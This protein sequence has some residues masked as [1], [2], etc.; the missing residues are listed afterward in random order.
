MNK[1][2]DYQSAWNRLVNREY[3]YEDISSVYNDLEILRPLVEKATPKAIEKRTS[4][5]KRFNRDVEYEV[6]PNC[7][8]KVYLFDRYCKNCGQALHIGEIK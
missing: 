4:Y 5:S 1:L 3:K 7:H 2:T 6:C 8:K